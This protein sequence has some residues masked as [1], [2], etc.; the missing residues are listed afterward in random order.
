MIGNLLVELKCWVEYSDRNVEK[1]TS[2]SEEEKL[3]DQVWDEIMDYDK[4]IQDNEINIFNLNV[5]LES[6]K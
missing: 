1:Y 6:T 4:I 3:G 5:N 2:L